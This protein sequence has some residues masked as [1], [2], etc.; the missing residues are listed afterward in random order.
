MNGT[1]FQSLFDFA[2]QIKV[3]LA[4]HAKKMKMAKVNVKYSWAKFEKEVETEIM[5]ALDEQPHS[6]LTIFECEWLTAETVYVEHLT[7][8][9]TWRFN[10]STETLII[11]CSSPSKLGSFYKVEITEIV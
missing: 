11:E 7:G 2:R 5:I 1:N 8:W 4:P 6:K 10:P 3:D 9:N